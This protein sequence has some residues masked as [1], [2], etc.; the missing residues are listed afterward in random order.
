[1]GDRPL[2]R[3]ERVGEPRRGGRERREG[4]HR[5]GS[6]AQ[7]SQQRFHPSIVHEARPGA[8]LDTIGSVGK[9]FSDPAWWPTPPPKPP[10]KISTAAIVFG[11][12]VPIVVIVILIVAVVGQAQACVGCRDGAFTRGLRGLHEGSG[13]H[14][15]DRSARTAAS[16]RRTPRPAAPT[17]RKAWRF[18]RS[19]RRR[20][21]TRRPSGRSRS[22]CRRRRRT[23]RAAASEGRSAEAR[24]GTRSETRST[25]AARSS[26]RVGKAAPPHRLRATTTTSAVA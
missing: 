12:F 16:C 14:L 5:D 19:S 7:R 11:T 20:A 23:S 6:C 4:E 24:H 1:M 18:R 21:P 3:L 25:P 17:C 9:D 22:A 13:R 10:R 2:P 26:G 8:R 15:G